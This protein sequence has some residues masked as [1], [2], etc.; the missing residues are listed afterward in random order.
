MGSVTDCDAWAREPIA[1]IGMSCKLPGDASSPERLWEM[2]AGGKSAW[3]K[4]RS[5]RFNQT[6]AY[7]PNKDKLNSVS[8]QLENHRSLLIPWILSRLI[9]PELQ[10]HVRGAHFMKEDPAFFD[11]AFFNYS[12]ETASTLDPQIRLQLE[13]V[14]EALENAGQPLSLVAGSKTSVFAGFFFTDY[15]DALLRDEDNLPRL[16][17]A[18][19]GLAMAS[20]RVSHF[21]DLRGASFTLDTGCSSTLVALH[22]GIQSL[23]S[24]EANMSVI[25]GASAM[26]NPDCFKTLS[27]IGFLSP[28][29][30]SYAFDSRA[31][32][33]G[34]GEGVAT[35]IIKR[36][37]DAIAAGDPVRAVIRESLLNQD[38]KT[39][40]ITTPSQ[41]AQEDLIRETY[42]KADIDPLGTQYFEAHGTGTPTGDPIE[43]RA[44]AAVFRPGRPIGQPLR[45][46]SVKTNIGHMEA[47]SGLGSIIKTVLALEKGFIPPSIHYE[48]PNPKLALEE[49][50]LKVATELEPWP[51][52]PGAIRRASVNSFGYG[53]TNAHV[54]IEQGETSPP[55]LNGMH[56]T[57]NGQENVQILA[58]AQISKTDADGYE[59]PSYKT[60]VLVLSAKDKHTC[61]K[62]VANL[63]AYLQQKS[64]AHPDDAD[65]FLQSLLYTLGQRR[66][67]FPWVAAGVIPFTNGLEKVVQ[68]LG[69]PNFIPSRSTRRP[70]IGMVFT[71]QG[72]QWYAM[73]RELI[74]CYPRFKAS[75]KE[76]DEYLREL[77]ADW[78]LMEEL[79]RTSATSRVNQ[80]ALSVPICVALQVSLVR[81]LR[82]FNITPSGVTSH[83]S[84][85]IAAA[86]TVGAICYREAMAIAYHRARLAS[87]HLKPGTISGGMVAVGQ[88][89]CEVQKY[90]DSERLKGKG[91]ALVACINSPQSVTVAGDLTAVIEV[92]QM[93]EADGVFARRIKVDAAY[94]SHH[95]EPIADPYRVA[96]EDTMDMERPE[97]S[98]DTVSFSSAVT[99]DRIM[100]TE[101]IADPEH[102]V[103]SL[104]Q[105]VQ[106][107]NA[108]MDMVLGDRDPSGSSIDVLVEVGPHTALGS[109]IREILAQAVF[110]GIQMPYFGC[111]VRN[112]NARDSLQNLA[113][114]LLRAGHPV[115][116]E[117]VNFPFGKWHHL[118]VLT[119]LP[120]YP[121]SHQNR[122]WLEPRR[123]LAIRQR[124]EAPHDLL[125]SLVPGVS[126]ESPSW[127]NTLRTGD[128]PWMRHH[129]VQS[130]IIYPGAGYVCL[131]I[132]AIKQI[133][134]NAR[135]IVRY[136]LRDI[137][138][139][140]AL[141]VLDNS[142]GIEINTA[143]R[144]ASHESLGLRGWKEF[145]IHSVTP[146]NRWTQHAKGYISVEVE[147]ENKAL[148]QKAKQDMAIKGYA[149]RIDPADLF[150]NL[151]SV[152]IYH[153]AM[154]RNIKKIVQSG[155]EPRA[156]TTV[157][158]A[159]TTV[160]GDLPRD[161]VLH[162]TTLD[163]FIV[164][165]YAAL[166]RAGGA[167]DTAR[168]PRSFRNI[169]VSA[170]ISH[171]PGHN[172]KVYPSVQ[173]LD[174]HILQC[175]VV[176]FDEDH[177]SP[178]VEMQEISLQSL[179]A[180]ALR[181]DSKPW[182]K[183]VCSKV[184][185]APDV[186]L[187]SPATLVLIKEKLCLP[188]SPR[189]FQIVMELRPVCVY[190]CQEA[191]ATLTAADVAHLDSHHVKF[192]TWMQK[193]VD[194][195]QSGLLGPG[196]E[197]WLMHDAVERRCRIAAVSKASVE[198][199]MIC[200]LGPHLAAVLRHEK[201]PLELMMERDQLLYR[202]YKGMFRLGRSMVQLRELLR[203]LVHKNPRARILE[204]GAGT[205][206][207]TRHALSVLGT[208]ETGGPLA[209]SYHFTD[210]SSGFFE[211][212]R[213]EFSD[214]AD[215]LV[216]DKLDAEMDPEAQGFD[217][218]SYDIVIACECL[219]AT[220][221]MVKT[222]SNV[223]SLMRPGGT[224]LVVE[225]TQDQVDV[226]FAFGL[227]PGW[228]LSEEPQRTSSPSL[229]I[230]FFDDV[231]NRSGFTGVDI[232]VRD[233]ESDDMHSLSVIMSTAAP[234]KLPELALEDIVIVTTTTESTL[235]KTWLESLREALSSP[236]L[237]V[238]TPAVLPLGSPAAALMGKI[239]VFVGEAEQPILHYLS[240]ETLDSIKSLVSASMALI[241]VTR[242]GTVECEDPKAGLASGFLRALR[243]EYIGK[244][245]VSLD[246][247]LKEPMC[248]GAGASA[249]SQVLRS[250]FSYSNTL[251]AEIPS[252]FE[253]AQRDGVILIPRLYKDVARNKAIWPH[254]VECS[255]AEPIP[256]EPFL[257]EACPLALQVGRSGLLD[258]LA[259][260][261]DQRLGDIS[262]TDVEIEPRAYGVN[263]RGGMT[264]TDKLDDAFMGLECSGIITCL[265]SEAAARGLSVGDRVFC[266]LH[267]T[268]RS[269]ARV[270]WKLVIRMPSWLG[271]EDAASLPVMYATAYM[272]LVDVA[273]LQR[274]QLV[275]IHEAAG[276]MGQAAIVLSQKLG[277]EIHVTVRSKAEGEL[278]M[279]RYGV[280]A[281][282]IFSS[283]DASF[284]AGIL[285]STNGY[286]VDVVLNSLAGPLLQESFN[287]VAPF[288][289]F[290]D[291]G[292][293]RD[294]EGNSTLEMRSFSRHVHFVALDIVDY[295]RHRATDTQ[296]ILLQ[297]ARLVDEMVAVP[298]H[299]IITQP[300][301]DISKVLRQLQTEEHVG[302][303]VLSVSPD[304]QVPVL[305]QEPRA[306]LSPN[307][308]YLL[309]GGVGGVGSSVAH[310]M[311]SHGARNVILLS[312]SA[313]TSS[314]SRN[315]VEELEAGCRVKAIS[316]DVSNAEDLAAA[317]QSCIRD[318]LPPVRGIIQG[319]MVLEDSILEH[320]SISSWRTAI[321]P[322]VAG[323]WN[324]H[325][326]FDKADELDFFIMLSSIS[327]VV[328]MASQSNY[329]AAGGFQDAI[330]RWRVSRGLP[331]V[332]ID[333]DAI[334]SV[335]YVSERANVAERMKRAGHVLLE[336]DCML[337]VLESAVLAPRDP[338]L[339]VGINH[340]PGSH[341]DLGS[342]A[343]IGRDARFLALRYNEGPGRLEQRKP[344]HI[345]SKPDHIQSNDTKSLARSLLQASSR[346]DAIQLVQSAIA[347][348]LC[349]MFMIPRGEIDLQRPP[350]SYGIDSLIAIELRNMFILQAATEISIFQILQS[351]SLLALASE[352]VSRS[353]AISFNN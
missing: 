8:F 105:P 58:K 266:L 328:G 142:E 69:S 56:E 190:F 216:F 82:E 89:S 149:R 7:H 332:S 145:E 54:I 207:A 16:F 81:L 63:T 278:L 15:K 272:G 289:Y 156:E 310:W 269:R 235:P 183:E 220:K 150:T 10:M 236:G 1:I 268:Y 351:T 46:G 288:G 211:A 186:S 85:E 57:V 113:A 90:L 114:S 301:S 333:L 60:K 239:C 172:F 101:E 40:T 280:R 238:F 275:L 12:A 200:H 350:S 111:L 2:L 78:S 187:L 202:Y 283:R 232:D 212:A 44:I 179:G 309:V 36:L 96:L 175:N 163:S 279:A 88:G 151:R 108:F 314:K 67:T 218:G 31:N 17:H 194:S 32:G 324:L 261:K 228:W 107:V 227:L 84:G 19:T 208:A 97:D 352:V 120:P 343:R 215:Y 253:Y 135:E 241:W 61:D 209:G 258:S 159:D 83:S 51:A 249:I 76:A 18:G 204:I 99:G 325:N 274:G 55:T 197:K 245:I 70:R 277:A 248:S 177:H 214:W 213:R 265:G 103:A 219:H 3:S 282:R 22:Q 330:A 195:A 21:F 4:I 65:R 230:P 304:E 136:H 14:Y 192:H 337:V 336:E 117:A 223:R 165:I 146:D 196:S 273:R 166:A 154:F 162:P 243:D 299:P 256:K 225:T 59:I 119:D 164:S 140:A 66:T 210:I 287:I 48:E 267:E 181:E 226:Q 153:G 252:E 262:P 344:D 240:A 62:M 335:G 93:A 45:I 171:E 125:G 169:S 148:L 193:L 86:Y 23:R 247:D 242:G 116:M 41:A 100:D 334:K 173:R 353:T 348:K 305:C 201:A 180:S 346:D 29:G 182:D 102:W 342:Q 80:T 313:G 121:W 198:G 254:P 244:K 5:S 339:I 297:V 315:L 233:C 318:G 191:I 167:E 263:F 94:H 49:W 307:A 290:V 132:E 264:A 35:V 122:H 126:S 217:L 294:L 255:T 91:E 285:A 349:D 52:A 302:K 317:L 13:S 168:I 139:M 34:R 160:P 71:G 345:Q 74:P 286:G 295:A 141:V 112:T 137:E 178:V 326:M 184:E 161:P 130:N 133:T 33:Y 6:G 64:F 118:R 292:T 246:L 260:S 38:G 73:G 24:G 257:Q 134:R 25:G 331:G 72:A 312:R 143:L 300:L 250:S 221:N 276:G 270:D 293:R 98:L 320:M 50:R 205:G 53:G 42:R 222:M 323:T 303:V 319:A 109:P 185:W 155:K 27:S 231:L 138:I 30:K 75:I 188:A 47:V 284:A 106:F 95:M 124:M 311:V 144:P 291:L 129:V 115:N 9:L 229:S 206:G 251:T 170:K 237:D 338:Q 147:G 199:E 176:V 308:S 321:Q 37:K 123:N 322:K 327:G 234:S 68:D 131:A 128:L 127:R 92:E 110:K 39:E 26:L 157:T 259:F 87:D 271:F 281:N 329:G 298:V 152:G 203:L 347:D 316:C 296:R 340:G 28:D 306:E 43:A 79:N 224:L 158:V 174:P 77:G 341:W 104:V 189:D 11:A 20:N